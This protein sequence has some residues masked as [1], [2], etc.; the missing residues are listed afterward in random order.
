M[1][2]RF[3]LFKPL[4]KTDRARCAYLG[5]DGSCV[6]L[7][8]R[9][10]PLGRQEY[11]KATTKVANLTI[12]QEQP[13]RE[14]VLR[15]IVLHES[16]LGLLS[17]PLATGKPV[18]IEVWPDNGSENTRAKGFVNQTLVVEVP[19][20]GRFQTNEIPYLVGSGFTLQGE[21]F[22]SS[23]GATEAQT[24]ESLRQINANGGY[25]GYDHC[26]I[27]A[28]DDPVGRLDRRLEGFT[29]AELGGAQ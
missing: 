14:R 7:F 1:A 25:W 5:P 27:V 17:I 9:T 26:A 29:P 2:K 24:A 28:F 10:T 13:S 20:L 18:R 21:G 16:A 12:R 19:G 8:E 6:V 4:K 23:L 22:D 15:R 11:V 3:D